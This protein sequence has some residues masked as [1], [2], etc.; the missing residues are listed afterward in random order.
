MGCLCKRKKITLTWED[1]ASAPIPYYNEKNEKS[2]EPEVDEFDE[3]KAKELVKYLLSS[4]LKFYQSQL[5]DVIN[6]NSKEFRKLF[7]GESDYIY[8]VKNQENFKK[9]AVK[10]ENFALLLKEWY[11]NDKKYH[12]CLKQLWKHNFVNFYDLKDLD[13][14]EIEKKLESS[15][16]KN[17]D[18]DIK[19]ELKI[20]IQNSYDMSE[21]FK[22]FIKTEYKE[23]DDII[24]GLEKGR[25]T[26]EKIEKTQKSKN[27]SIKENIDMIVNKILDTTLPIFLEDT[28]TKKEEKQESKTKNEKGAKNS[29][30]V[31]LTGNKKLHLI[32]RVAKMYITG[33]APK[34]FKIDETLNEIGSLVNQFDVKKYFEP[35]TKD[36]YKSIVNNK[37]TAYGIL[38]LSFLNLC[39]NIASTHTFLD[40]SK[41]Q[42]DELEKRL[43][44]IKEKFERHKKE[45]DLL[46]KDDIEGAMNKIEEIRL[47]FEED[48]SEIEILIQDIEKEI[49]TQKSEKKH[50]Y[51]KIF[52]NL[53]MMGV[54]AVLASNNSSSEYGVSALFNGISVA[55]DVVAIVQIGKNIDK[56]KSIL[57][58]AK[59]EEKQIVEAIKELREKYK[60][61]QLK[62]AP[63]EFTNC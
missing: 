31:E 57:E 41:T 24:K 21:K 40:N 20:I 49:K 48:R 63:L 12:V 18:E 54:N 23:L 46:P 1:D 3:E 5:Y 44:K 56:L 58:K 17:W 29:N 47:K 62:A 15:N 61:Y 55:T 42:I 50:G 38:G 28:K 52:S 7:E 19:E 34:D 9:L 35:M 45:I 6:L 60:K 39:Y 30:K 53:G 33:E 4:D 16:Y 8:N 14:E 37:Y 11:K 36:N 13:D 27:F 26:M 32:K 25:K 22:I 2:I 59:E 43:A 51:F 10:F